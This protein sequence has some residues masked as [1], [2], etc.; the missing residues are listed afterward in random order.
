MT[1]P[2][3]VRRLTTIMDIDVVGFSSMSANNEEHA[4]GLL[5]KRL[6]TARALI[7]G[8]RGRI[9]KSTG[10]G[11]LAEFAS[12]V[13]AVRAALEIQEA[14]RS[15]NGQAG[16]DDQMVLRIGIN[17][18]DV[19]ESGDDLLGDAV[20]V[21]ARLES[22]AVPGGVCVSSA[23]F[24]QIQGKLTLGAE[25]MGAQHVKNIPRPIH[26]YRLTIGDDQSPSAM[27][28]SLAPPSAPAAAAEA[29]AAQRRKSVQFGILAGA[30]AVVV[31]LAAGGLWFLNQRQAPAPPP[32]QMA[33]STIPAAS[34]AAPRGA[35]SSQALQA[36]ERL[37]Q[38][39]P[40]VPAPPPVTLDK[41]PYVA[42]E[43]PFVAHWREARLEDYASAED[44]KAM[45]INIRGWM[46]IS[47]R[48]TDA[49]TATRAAM[50]ECDAAVDREIAAPR[51]YDRC[52]LYAVGND[53][54]WSF[55]PPPLPPAPYIPSRA[56]SPPVPVDPATIPLI[57]PVAVR[58][59]K[60]HYLGS[61]RHRSF[62]LGHGPFNWWSI[63]DT[64]ADAVHRNLQIC[65]HLTG[66]PCMIYAVDDN[67]IVRVPK[68]HRPT[69]I[70]TPQAI[71]IT[72]PTQRNA[73][74]HYLIEN[75][76]RA[77]AVSANGRLGIVSGRT[78]ETSAVND[79]V[80]ECSKAGGTDC[81]IK[82]VGP[83]LV[84]P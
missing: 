55:R 58:N 24:E 59:L 44:F 3:L 56:L 16:P 50:E 5:G 29:G 65:G 68:L 49:A 10:D 81:K 4:L 34:T 47:T 1:E 63:N 48:R 80:A 43:V 73:V 54:V 83:F 6:A 45:A 13:E 19:V 64:D 28:T 77:L 76:W 31:V 11:L 25:D 30:A 72:D 2:Q 39:S 40:A 14:M 20:N 79:A 17:L 57:G 12:P 67:V 61:P 21:A 41:R 37:G 69:D 46:G 38:V 82:A 52:M 7:T 71:E 35:P 53:V 60:D 75:D 22:I 32:S 23:V 70:V 74:E 42:S 18:G 66:R 27:G 26:A 62:V 8:H 9:F 78:D 36:A 15:V 84:E 33:Q 51:E